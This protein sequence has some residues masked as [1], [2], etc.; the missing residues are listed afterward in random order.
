MP[1]KLYRVNI[2]TGAVSDGV[3]LKQF[4]STWIPLASVDPTIWKMRC[5]H[6]LQSIVPGLEVVLGR[7]LDSRARLAASLPADLRHTHP[8]ACTSRDQNFGQGAAMLVFTP[9]PAPRRSLPCRLPCTPVAPR[10]V[11]PSHPLVAH[12][13][14]GFTQTR[15]ND[16]LPDIAGA[17]YTDGL[18]TPPWGAAA[19]PIAALGKWTAGVD[20]SVV[21]PPASGPPAPC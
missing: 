5:D 13:G 2:V 11:R 10:S 8:C 12:L 15:Y 17:D 4:P 7:S 6:T 9:R 18:A 19:G 21:R 16:D 3:T 1:A 14:S 20:F